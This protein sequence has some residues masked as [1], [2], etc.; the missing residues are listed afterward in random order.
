MVEMHSKLGNTV[1][2]SKELTLQNQSRTFHRTL[3]RRGGSHTPPVLHR[4][5]PAMIKL[6]P[7]CSPV[8]VVERACVLLAF[9]LALSV[10][11]SADQQGTT[12]FSIPLSINENG[13]SSY[14]LEFGV[15]PAATT[16]I[17]L[18]LGEVE[19][20]PLPPGGGMG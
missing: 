8:N 19:Y 6:T 20:P 18:A 11:A 1:M 16:G 7:S 15:H 4:K 2:K 3:P 5:E 12:A 17:D 9:V 10:G 13:I 14:G